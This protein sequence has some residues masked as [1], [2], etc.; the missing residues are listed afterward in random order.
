V[1]E[2]EEF[3][4]EVFSWRIRRIRRRFWRIPGNAP[5]GG[6]GNT[7]PVSPPQGNPG[8]AFAKVASN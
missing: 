3:I 6:S 2:V 4:V 8:G 5:A 7:P 1:E